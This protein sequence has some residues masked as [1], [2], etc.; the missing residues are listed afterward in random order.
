MPLC[1][2]L[3]LQPQVAVAQR[4]GCGEEELAMGQGGGCRAGKRPR[5]DRLEAS[6]TEVVLRK[7]GMKSFSG[8]WIG[9]M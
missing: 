1:G 7:E 9:G 2:S 6:S 4:D 5:E 8:K 3:N